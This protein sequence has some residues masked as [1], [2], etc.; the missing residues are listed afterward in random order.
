MPHT[1]VPDET[2]DSDAP[3]IFNVGL[4]D[5][6]SGW[7]ECST[8]DTLVHPR[9]MFRMCSDIS[10]EVYVADMRVSDSSV[11]SQIWCYLGR[12]PD[13][14]GIEEYD[15]MRFGSVEEAKTWLR[16]V[17]KLLTGYISENDQ[18]EDMLNGEVRLEQR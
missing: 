17:T 12:H 13:V 15:D 7:F 6:S 14:D 4:Q 1:Y 9:M 18:I 16:E 3:E 11:P 10:C 2:T 5:I 8:N